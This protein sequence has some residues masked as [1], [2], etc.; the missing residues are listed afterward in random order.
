VT[1]RRRW[2]APVEVLAQFDRTDAALLPPLARYGEPAVEV[3]GDP[4]EEQIDEIV[5]NVTAEGGAARLSWDVDL[6]P[7]V[8]G[9]SGIEV[10]HDV[11]PTLTPVPGACD[12]YIV[13]NWR[14]DDP[15]ATARSIATAA[16]LRLDPGPAHTD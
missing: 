14:A 11:D 9:R 16:G 6:D 12:L 15:A 13:I 1:C 10:C 7:R 4:T 5:A 3:T 2:P 8:G